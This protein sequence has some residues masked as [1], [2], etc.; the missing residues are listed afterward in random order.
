VRVATIGGM[1]LGGY[2]GQSATELDSHANMAV[3]GNGV[4]V[5]SKSGMSATVT[6][7][8]SDIPPMEDVEIGDVAMAYDDPIRGTTYLLVMRNALLIPTMDHNLL[9]PFLAREAGLKIDETPKCRA[10]SP[11]VL[12]HL[13]CDPALN[14]IFLYFV[15]RKLNIDEMENWES[16][17]V[18]YLTPDSDSWD[19]NVS[20]FA[21]QEAAML[22]HNSHIVE[23]EPCVKTLFVEADLGSLYKEPATWDQFNEIVD[24][25]MMEDEE[26][27]GN[28]DVLTCKV[29]SF[30]LLIKERAI[31]SNASMAFGATTIN[32]SACDIFEAQL[33]DAIEEG[34]STLSAV[35][36]GQTRGVSAEHLAK[37]W[38][39]SHD[40]AAWTLEVTTQLLHTNDGSSLSRNA[41]TDDRAVGYK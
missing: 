4:L 2:D 20:H 37:I 25:I 21:E 10:D 1:R 30:S 35:R 31:L 28:I 8:L 19:P 7:F 40:D 23:R 24:R 14:G 6:P 3:V 11:P 18:V 41:G 33:R 36:T 17:P 5:I 38:Q 15:T 34:F 16:Y 26:P 9:P 27:S 13:I 39:I 22:D 29:S 32:K 12:N